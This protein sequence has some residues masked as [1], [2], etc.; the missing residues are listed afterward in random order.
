MGFVGEVPLSGYI[1]NESSSSSSLIVIIIIVYLLLL[2][3][4]AITY[5]HFDYAG[6]LARKLTQIL[7]IITSNLHLSVGPFSHTSQVCIYKVANCNDRSLELTRPGQRDN[8]KTLV[9]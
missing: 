1:A 8:I 5:V 4:L 6:K 2:L 7:L 3:S 9:K